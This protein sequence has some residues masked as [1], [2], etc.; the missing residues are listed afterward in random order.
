MKFAVNLTNNTD[1]LSK[2]TK[3]KTKKISQTITQI[4]KNL[5]LALPQQ[6]RQNRAD[7]G[8]FAKFSK[9]SLVVLFAIDAD[10][11]TFNL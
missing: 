1:K 8:S 11:L 10:T 3:S 2:S 9:R 7:L 6:R 4:Y 5:E